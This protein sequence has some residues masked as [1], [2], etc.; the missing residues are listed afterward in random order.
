[1]GLRRP[2]LFKTG[3]VMSA[4]SSKA[5]RP[6]L[7]G[8]AYWLDKLLQN[9]AVVRKQWHVFRPLLRRALGQLRHARGIRGKSAVVRRLA[10]KAYAWLTHHSGLEAAHSSLKGSA[11]LSDY[12]AQTRQIPD[13]VPMSGGVAVVSLPSLPATAVSV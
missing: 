2:G 13:C 11:A 9:V 10:P 8:R 4:E 7:R 5:R 1:M 3:C 12:I 6:I